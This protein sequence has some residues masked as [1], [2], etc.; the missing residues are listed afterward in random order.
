[1]SGLITQPAGLNDINADARLKETLKQTNSRIDQL[2][3]L[4]SGSLS[5]AGKSRLEYRLTLTRDN[6]MVQ[7]FLRRKTIP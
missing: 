3:P 6:F 5:G 1:M 4:T 2:L 7:I